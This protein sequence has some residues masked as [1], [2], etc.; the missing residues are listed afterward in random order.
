MKMT[1]YIYIMNFLAEI[2]EPEPFVF[3]LILANQYKGEVLW[4]S[5]NFIVKI[6]GRYYDTE[7][8][9]YED[10][11]DIVTWSNVDT[12]SVLESANSYEQMKWCFIEPYINNDILTYGAN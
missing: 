1:P 8:E 5:G 12:L 10:E 2:P 6:D 7:G 3:C 9:I 4:N 11:L